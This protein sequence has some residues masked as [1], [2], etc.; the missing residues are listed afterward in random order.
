MK[1]SLASFFRQLKGTSCLSM[2]FAELLHV[3]IC[4][5]YSLPAEMTLDES[6]NRI[7]SLLCLLCFTPISGVCSVLKNVSRMN[8]CTYRHSNNHRIMNFCN[9]P[10]LQSPRVHTFS[11]LLFV[12]FIQYYNRYPMSYSICRPLSV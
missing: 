9:L 8:E 2:A 7:F 11:I 12:V 3:S 4:L 10:P 1:L 6:R 5:H